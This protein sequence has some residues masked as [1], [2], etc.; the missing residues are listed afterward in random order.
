MGGVGNGASSLTDCGHAQAGH[1]LCTCGADGAPPVSAAAA[2]S[3]VQMTPRSA[4]L[5]GVPAAAASTISHAENSS[6]T[7][8]ANAPSA[9][10]N[11][12][13]AGV[14]CDRRTT[15]V[16]KRYRNQKLCETPLYQ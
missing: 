13:Q 3:C 5:P 4:W 7:T 9:A 12:R 2:G 14:S 15:G 6:C 10:P 1:F 8:I 16:S 11:R